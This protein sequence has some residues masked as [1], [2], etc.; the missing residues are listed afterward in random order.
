MAEIGKGR[1][2]GFCPNG[3]STSPICKELDYGRYA[4]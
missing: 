1:E 3:F 2:T 4:E